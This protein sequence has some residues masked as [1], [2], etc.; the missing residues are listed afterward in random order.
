MVHGDRVP[1]GR[2]CGMARG[3]NG[4]RKKIL[5]SAAKPCPP[6]MVRLTLIREMNATAPWPWMHISPT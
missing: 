5:D 3:R 6:E 2:L 1:V 4:R